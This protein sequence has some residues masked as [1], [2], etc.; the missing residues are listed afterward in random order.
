MRK[1]IFKFK[2]D[3]VPIPPLDEKA[4]QEVLAFARHG[5][6]VMRSDDVVVGIEGYPRNTEWVKKG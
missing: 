2:V 5:F 6:G 3:K 1:E 4:L